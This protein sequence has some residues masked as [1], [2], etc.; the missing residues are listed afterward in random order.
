MVAGGPIP[1]C[2]I[3]CTAV[4]M[5]LGTMLLSAATAAPLSSAR[6]GVNNASIPSMM[7]GIPGEA[8]RGHRWIK[9]AANA[10]LE[11]E[12]QAIGVWDVWTSGQFEAVVPPG[13]WA[14]VEKLLEG[15]QWSYHAEDMQEML[16]NDKEARRRTPYK[17]GMRNNEFYSA[18]RNLPEID[19][20]VDFL[21]ELAPADMI[22]EDIVA[23][24]TNEG[25]EIRGIKIVAGAAELK[26]EDRP[27][28]V[29]HGCHHSGE[30][31]TAMGM[32]YFIEQ[33]ITT[34]G[35]DPA[36]T[37]IADNYEFDLIP[38]MNVDGFLFGWAND[39]FRTWRKTR[40][41][42]EANA[43]A[44]AECE[45]IT[46]GSCENCIGTDPN[47]NWDVN[48]CGIG[49][50]DNPCSGSYCGSGPNGAPFREAEVRTMAD[51]VRDRE[52]TIYMDH[53]CCGDMFLQ[54]YGKSDHPRKR[55]LAFP[56]AAGAI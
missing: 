17:R 49:S 32:V 5:L 3:D 36:L 26:A 31:I 23:G 40:S 48:W 14:G 7:N 19:D 51:F 27:S 12:F 28:F 46:P 18:W 50:S 41:T 21:R 39:Q 2:L 45:L 53:H 6:T 30:W 24:V 52:T 38:V 13:K 54:P 15:R 4:M 22:I 8:M 35:R 55:F 33:I 10:S 43:V 44:F 29:M 16:E 11:E 37:R 34:Y 1:D 25:R 47:R 20:Y 9:L 42:H 56:H